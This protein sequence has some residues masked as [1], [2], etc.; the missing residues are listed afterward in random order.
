LEEI[1][2]HSLNVMLG[3]LLGARYKVISVLGSGGFG[4]TY[5]AEDTQRPGNPCCVLKHLT[6]ASP[7]TRVLEHVR[8]LFQAEAETLEKLGRHDQIPQ[9]LAYFEEN[10][11]FYLVQEFVAGTPLGEE[12]DRG[13]RFSESQVTTMLEDVLGILDYVHGQGVIH[14]DIKPENL[15]RRQPD[16]KFVLIDFGAVKTIGTTIAEATGETSLSVPVYTSGY[17]ASEQCLGRPRFNSDLYSLGMVAIQTLTGMRPSQLPHDYNTSEVIWRDQAQVSDALAAFLDKMVAYHF[18]HRYQSAME[19]LQALRPIISASPTVMTHPDTWFS[20]MGA[21]FVPTNQTQPQLSTPTEPLHPFPRKLRRIVAIAGSAIAATLVIAVFARNFSQPSSG[22]VFPIPSSNPGPSGGSDLP[23]LPG[24]TAMEFLRSRTSLGE[25]LLNKWQVIP[26]KQKGVEEFAAGN[27]SKAVAALQVARQRDRTDPETL[28]YLNNA[29][30]GTAKSYE[31]AVAVPFGDEALR[32]A[33]EI[34]RGVAQAQ[35]EVNRAGGIQGI[36]LKVRLVDDANQR[37]D[38]GNQREVARQLGTLL[39]NAP[40]TLGVIGHGSSDTSIAAAE[41][42]QANQLVMISPVSS[43]V[44]LSNRGSYIF[45]TMPS[46]QLTAKALVSHMLNTL[47]KRK[48]VVF[49]NSASDYSKSL[50]SEFKNALF[51]SAN[52]DLMGEFDLSRPDFDAYES[53]NESIV[54]GAEVMLLASDH[55]MSDRA[56]Q[57]VGVNDKRLKILAGDSFFS[58]KLLK[59]AGEQATGIV[60]AVPASLTR[61]PFWQKFTGLWG[62]QVPLSWRSSLAYDAAQSLI[63]AL[64]SDPTRS[65]VQ[66]ALS[67]PGFSAMGAE[68]PVKF[69]P[70]GDR[71]RSVRLMTVAPIASGKTTQY[72]FKSLSP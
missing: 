69:L 16:G 23:N 57:V 37:E 29:R 46:D 5:I 11:E 24:G 58:P 47:K 19:A 39:A 10:R 55:T 65:G 12:L 20:R 42:Y 36:P 41:V 59:I 32:S 35:D 56:M 63:K 7:N 21:T 28:I 43:A 30:I 52:V 54:K 67:Q 31:I 45:R 34:L 25:K 50:K 2:L 1:L 4:H 13:I 64:R 51:Y 40:E 26:D 66:R 38:G 22:P 72:I 3:E 70:T 6:F 33:L 62:N 44:Q 27:F 14:R 48:V 9:L 15:I 61:S 8:R 68:G 60:V 71:Q 17:G 49:F 53:I 18:I